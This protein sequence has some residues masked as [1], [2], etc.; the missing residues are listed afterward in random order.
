M[1]WYNNTIFVFSA[2]H[3]SAQIRLPEYNSA[4]GYFSIPIFFF[5]PRG[6]KGE[7]RDEIIQQTDIMPTIL[8]MLHYDKP[9]VG[10]GRDLVREE[11]SPFAFNVCIWGKI[12]R[13]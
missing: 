8:G 7:M 5:T 12:P 3:A 13:L 6:A 1:Q 9:Y 2:D 4:W 11:V 10:F